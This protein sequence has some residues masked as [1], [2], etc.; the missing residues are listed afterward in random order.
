MQMSFCKATLA[1]AVGSQ[2]VFVLW[3]PLYLWEVSSAWHPYSLGAPEKLSKIQRTHADSSAALSCW[4]GTSGH[5]P[6]WQRGA[7]EGFRWPSIKNQCGQCDTTEG[8]NGLPRSSSAENSYWDRSATSVHR[9]N[10]HIT[11]VWSFYFPGNFHRQ[12]SKK[13]VI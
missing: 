11:V 6:S 13:Q 3:S 2:A 7:V 12:M 8:K 9:L 1:L 4:T 5:R 10:L